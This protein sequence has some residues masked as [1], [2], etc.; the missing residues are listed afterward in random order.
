ML[1][2]CMTQSSGNTKLVTERAFFVFVNR[3]W[4]RLYI[5]DKS[6]INLVKKLEEGSTIYTL[7]TN[8]TSRYFLT[9]SVF[10]FYACRFYCI[11]R[12]FFSYLQIYECQQ[13]HDSTKEF[14]DAIDKEN[15]Q[16]NQVTKSYTNVTSVKQLSFLLSNLNCYIVIILLENYCSKIDVGLTF[17]QPYCRKTRLNRLNH[18][19]RNSF[20][21]VYRKVLSLDYLF[22]DLLI[23]FT[24]I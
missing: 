21:D 8:T 24:Y 1:K 9:L 7:S 22:D 20:T 13:N 10:V 16:P 6:E 18:R 11:V 15:W 4:L 23:C 2:T 12:I 17:S 5:M 14:L 19:H 3:F